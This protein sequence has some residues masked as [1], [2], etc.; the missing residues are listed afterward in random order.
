MTVSSNAREIV[1]SS[2][3]TVHNYAKATNSFLKTSFGHEDLHVEYYVRELLSLV[4]KNAKSA[5]TILSLMQV[6]EKLESIKLR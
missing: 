6:Y 1:D 2:P 4:V 3:S 5:K